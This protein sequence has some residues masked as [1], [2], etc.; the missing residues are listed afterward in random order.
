M[1]RWCHGLVFAAAFAAGCASAAPPVEVQQQTGDGSDGGAVDLAGGMVV[2]NCTPGVACNTTSPGD[3]AMGTAFCS[4]NVLSC[5]PNVTTQ[6]CYDGPAGTMGKG[7]CKP[8]TQTCIG[9]LGSC[10]GEVTPAAVENCFNDIDDDCD[11]VVNN[12]CPTTITTGTPHV[13]TARGNSTGGSPFSLR[14]PAGSFVSKTVIYG[15]NTDTYLSGLDVYC[16]TPTLVR[17][18]T[19]YSVTVA[20]SGTAIS[21]TGGVRTSGATTTFTCSAGFTPGWQTPDYSDSGGLDALGLTCAQTAVALDAT[22]KLT[23]MQTAAPAASSTGNNPD[24]Y[25]F[26]TLANDNCAAGEVLVGYDGRNGNWIDYFAA[27]CAPLQV[28]YQ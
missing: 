13:L 5:V 10:S 24:G 26:G 9:T 18:A 20:V 11:G 15:D 23:F 16:G 17:G 6:A 21:T 2:D 14:C 12:G 22:N 4:G 8:G 19:S 3:C 25:N 1:G 7:A 27:V 28:V